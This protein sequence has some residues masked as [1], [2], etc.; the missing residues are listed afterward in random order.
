MPPIHLLK[1]H[2]SRPP[3]HNIPSSRYL[4]FARLLRPPSQVTLGFY[5]LG[6]Q[7]RPSAPVCLW[8]SVR[9]LEL[10][11]LYLQELFEAVFA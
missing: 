1:Q 4:D 11:T 10:Q 7:V 2:A 5:G 6:V 3:D 8:I 9:E